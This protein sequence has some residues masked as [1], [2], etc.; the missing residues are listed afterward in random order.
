MYM[1]VCDD[2]SEELEKVKELLDAWRIERGSSMHY[3]TYQM[4]IRDRDGRGW[5]PDG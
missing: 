4:C 5:T 1:A 3:K 2:Q